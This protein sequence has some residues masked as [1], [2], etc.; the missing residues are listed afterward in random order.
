[1]TETNEFAIRNDQIE[2]GTE[3]TR[4]DGYTLDTI[5]RDSGAWWLHREGASEP[6]FLGDTEK[7]AAR[8]LTELGYEC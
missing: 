3:V 6:L 1:M 2:D 8:Y 7:N 5:Y 4:P